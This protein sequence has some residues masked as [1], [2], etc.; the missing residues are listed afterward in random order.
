MKNRRPED[1]AKWGASKNKAVWTV[2]SITVHGGY[3]AFVWGGTPYNSD[4]IKAFFTP[5]SE[6]ESVDDAMQRAREWISSA[7]AEYA[8]A[9]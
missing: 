5:M 7:A 1:A 8:K 6:C 3:I 9:A 2:T 4:P